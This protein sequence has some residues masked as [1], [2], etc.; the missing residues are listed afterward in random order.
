MTSK[1]Q[2][3]HHCP[4]C[5]NVGNVRCLKKQHWRP[6]EIHGKSGHHGDFSVC[7]KCDGS[8]KRAEKAERIE[9]QKEREEQERLRKEEA[10]RKKREEKE[11]RRAAKEKARQEKHPKHESK[12]VKKKHKT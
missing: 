3:Q 1:K 12:D 2:R 8:D 6:C 4:V 10:E 7:V 9:R 11:R 5:T